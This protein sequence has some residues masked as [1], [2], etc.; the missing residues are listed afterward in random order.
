VTGWPK[1][2]RC[3][4]RNYSVY[5]M[6]IMPCRTVGTCTST[7]SIGLGYIEVGGRTHYTMYEM[8]NYIR[9]KSAAASETA[10]EVEVEV[11]SLSHPAS[12]TGMDGWILQGSSGLSFSL[13]FCAFCMLV[14]RFFFLLYF[15]FFY[16]FA[17]CTG[18]QKG[19]RLL[20][21]TNTLLISDG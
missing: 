15:I 13:C 2:N 12:P 8:S 21:L 3:S 10:V 17:S 19:I 9:C 11:P 1:R 7:G 5:I 16:I 4:A 18:H 14:F 6:I 20:G